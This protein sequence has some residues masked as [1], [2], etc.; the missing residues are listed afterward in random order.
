M[1]KE[2]ERYDLYNVWMEKMHNKS[3]QICM[4]YGENEFSVVIE[5]A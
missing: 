1:G 2:I 5:G 3:I 4:L